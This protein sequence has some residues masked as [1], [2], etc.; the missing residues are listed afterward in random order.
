MKMTDDTELKCK[1]GYRSQRQFAAVRAEPTQTAL[2]VI[3][4]ACSVTGIQQRSEWVIISLGSVTG[5]PAEKWVGYN[6][7]GLGPTVGKP[8]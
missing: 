1:R 3:L 8:T 5:I 4:C 7:I 2:G 6:L